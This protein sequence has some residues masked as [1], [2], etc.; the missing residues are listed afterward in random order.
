MV[1]MQ[2]Q[3]RIV[4]THV[5]NAQKLA[6]KSI[7]VNYEC[8]VTLVKL[9]ANPAYRY[10]EN[11]VEELQSLQNGGIT[12]YQ[13]NMFAIIIEKR[14]LLARQQTAEIELMTSNEGIVHLNNPDEYMTPEKRE[15]Y[16]RDVSI[17]FDHLNQRKQR[18]E[19]N[20]G[21]TYGEVK[22]AVHDKIHEDDVA[23]RGEEKAQRF[24]NEP[25]YH[26]A[27]EP[28]GLTVYEDGNAEE[29]E[30]LRQIENAREKYTAKLAAQQKEQEQVEQ[31]KVAAQQK[32]QQATEQQKQSA[33]QTQQE[34]SQNQQLADGEKDND[35]L[36]GEEPGQK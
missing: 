24:Y 29:Q 30:I 36:A 19:Y 28:I 8:D 1:H 7:A 20:I 35:F 25:D 4:D 11:Q 33:Q 17:A 18:P 22:H 16:H 12:P 2:T 9:K 23:L 32:M 34:Q 27:S 14:T 15:Q 6:D 31:A 5:E 10:I 21:Y 13:L 3:L 26:N